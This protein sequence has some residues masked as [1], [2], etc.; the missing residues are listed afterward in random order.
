MKIFRFLLSNFQILNFFV[1]SIIVGIALGLWYIPNSSESSLQVQP[2][3]ETTENKSS[4]SGASI[5]TKSEEEEKSETIPSTPQIS[6]NQSAESSTK[7]RPPVG[8]TSTPPKNTGNPLLP[9]LPPEYPSPIERTVVVSPSKAVS[10]LGNKTYLGHFPYQENPRNRL[11]NMGK[12][13]H[14]TEF[15][16]Q[17]TAIAFKKMK[18]DAKTQGVELILISGF[19][20]VAAQKKLF[21]HQ[22]QKRGNKEAAAKLSAPPGH[23][24]HH[25]GYALDIGDGKQPKT[26]LK[27]QFESTQAYIWLVNNAHKYGFELSFPRNNGQGVSFEPWHW[28]Y[29]GSSRANQIFRR[30]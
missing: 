28:R 2:N 30:F 8:I 9:Q 11:V 7:N 12:Y 25:T 10:P 17:E 27:F 29:I 23:S 24:E 6:K 14:R 22:I 16:D 18:T 26:D 20:S 3:Q 4:T 13:Y 1:A 5:P 21:L 15:L 19:R